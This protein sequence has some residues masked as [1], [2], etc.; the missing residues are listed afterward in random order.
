MEAEAVLN[1]T[2]PKAFE[3]LGEKHEIT[4]EAINLNAWR[5]EATGDLEQAEK[6]LNPMALRHMK[7][8]WMTF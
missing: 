5:L 4:L 1:A 6:K 2:L 7:K 3:E 8:Y